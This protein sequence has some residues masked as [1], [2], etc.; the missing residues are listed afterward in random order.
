MPNRYER[1]AGGGGGF[2][3][4]QGS[5]S[6]TIPGY[7]AV[8]VIM[9]ARSFFP[10]VYAEGGYVVRFTALQNYYADYVGRWKLYNGQSASTAYE[11]RW[12]YAS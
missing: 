11:I 8:N 1:F 6:G 7:D 4:S 12:E 5:M 10:N 3:A 9:H 2:N